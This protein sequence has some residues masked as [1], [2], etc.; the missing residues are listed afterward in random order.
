MA[1]QGDIGVQT[2]RTTRPAGR[3]GGSIPAFILGA[4]AAAGFAVFLYCASAHNGPRP[5]PDVAID[6]SLKPSQ[7]PTATAPVIAEHTS[8]PPPQ[9]PSTVGPSPLRTSEDTSGPDNT[10]PRQPQTEPSDASPQPPQQKTTLPPNRI[11]SVTK[12]QYYRATPFGHAF[13]DVPGSY[14]AEVVLESFDNAKWWLGADNWRK[15]TPNVTAVTTKGILKCYRIWPEDGPDNNTL[16]KALFVVPEGATVKE[17]RIGRERWAAPRT[18][19][20]GK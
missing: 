13:T 12:Y 9:A 7:A 11:V 17:M 18:V 3:G 1:W 5:I 10:A 20:S 14:Y 2:A 4:C 15:L 19:D 8:F 16:I 6:F